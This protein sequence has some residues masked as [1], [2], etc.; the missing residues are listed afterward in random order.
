[1]SVGAIGADIQ[2]DRSALGELRAAFAG[3]LISPDDASYEEHRRVWNGSID[4]Y[5]ALIARCGG[6]AD[7]IAA[8]RFARSTGLPVA[9]RGGGHSLPGHSVCNG[10]IVVDLGLMKRIRV[11]PEARTARAQAGVLLGELDRETQA[12]GLAV[13]A[14]IVT[15]TGLSG[16]TLGGGIGWLMRKHGLT[17]D[18]L[19]SVDLVTADG[20]IVR[21]S[22]AENADL[23]WGVRGG[24]GNF[25]IVTELEVRLNAVGPTVLGGPIVWAMEDSPHVLRFYRE[26]IREAPDELTTIVIHRRAPA[27]PTYP[28]ELH[29]EHVVIVAC[30]YAGPVEE[31]ERVMRPLRRFGAPL[32][33]LCEPKPY[34]AHQAMFDS[35][36]PHGRHYYYRACDVAELTDEVIDIT[37]DHSL[38]I[39]SPLTALPIFQLGGAVSRVRDEETAFNGRSAGHTFNIGGITETAEGFDEEREWSRGLWSALR[40]HHTSVYV[41]FLMDEGE[42]RIRQSYGAEKYARLK[43]LKRKYDPDNVF[44]LNQNIRPD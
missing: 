21:A 8:L 25:G 36:Y 30:C 2:V 10:G 44:R 15:H 13:P 12:C 22:E 1:M 42:E 16:L 18:Q 19:L 33:D 37:V 43:T 39:R 6:V 41:N 4:R 26:W 27:L 31:G 28:V 24:G 40:P 23:F 34:V 35:A 3:E 7:V 14:G 38:R 20:E 11:D 29:G 5:P 9:V 17:I 32:L